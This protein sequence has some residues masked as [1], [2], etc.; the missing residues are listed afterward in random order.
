MS[1]RAARQRDR[2]R[3]GVPA[4]LRQRRAQAFG[5]FFVRE[6]PR[7][8]QKFVRSVARPAASIAAFGHGAREID[9]LGRRSKNSNRVTG[10]GSPATGAGAGAVVATAGPP[11]RQQRAGQ[12]ERDPARDARA[13]AAPVEC[14]VALA[15]TVCAV[16][17]AANLRESLVSLLRS[18]NPA[19]S[20]ACSNCLLEK[21]RAS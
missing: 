1:D 13:E 21:L 7:L 3:L 6:R 5:I 12:R 20:Y 16:R 14:A 2:R 19:P 8:Q 10:V 11:L 17:H 15:R 4:R 18:Q 9:S